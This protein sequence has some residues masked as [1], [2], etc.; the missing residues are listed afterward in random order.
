M[1][2]YK[3]SQYIPIQIISY[4]EGTG[5]LKILFPSGKTYIYNVNPYNYEKLYILLKKKNYKAAENL[6]RNLSQN[7]EHTEEEKNEML[8]ELYNKGYLH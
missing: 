4:M 7:K 3:K 6:L 5:E 1:N 8:N 2:W